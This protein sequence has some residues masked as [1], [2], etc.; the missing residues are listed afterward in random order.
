MQFLGFPSQSAQDGSHKKHLPSPP[1]WPGAAHSEQTGLPSPPGAQATHPMGQGAHDDPLT[2][3]LPAVHALHVVGVLQLVQ[4]LGH[5]EK[6]TVS[7]Q[8]ISMTVFFWNI[9]IS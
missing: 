5:V 6:A 8:R 9:V 4:F 1:R 7:I 3:K 2:T